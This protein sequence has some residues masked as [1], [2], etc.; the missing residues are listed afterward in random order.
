MS[1]R[2]AATRRLATLALLALALWL[3]SCRS[4]YEFP[5]FEGG[6]GRPVPS[7]FDV[8][9][10]VFLVGDAGAVES[11]R[12]PLRDRLRTDVEYWSRELARDS[13][14]S[15]IFLGDNVYPYGVHEPGHPDFPQDS[16][17]LWSQVEVVAGS[18]AL[19]H[20]TT[21]LFVPAVRAQYTLRG[22]KTASPSH[23][24]QSNT[25][26]AFHSAKRSLICSAI[27]VSGSSSR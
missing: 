4:S 5:G 21:G 17:R 22:K 16:A 12:S 20:K 26:I 1:G 25:P 10:V 7:P 3:A 13:G 6:L 27:C 2:D 9:A 24:P 23:R 8:D 11:G 19:E 14:V 15:V 18:A